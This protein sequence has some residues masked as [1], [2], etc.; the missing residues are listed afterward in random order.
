MITLLDSADLRGRGSPSRRKVVEEVYCFFF[1]LFFLYPGPGSR[2][3]SRRLNAQ[4][5]VKKFFV[6]PVLGSLPGLFLPLF[7]A[8]LTFFPPFAI[9]AA[10]VLSL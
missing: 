8:V 5:Y 3:T 2:Y 9:R 6:G 7:E 4:A 10:D 1:S